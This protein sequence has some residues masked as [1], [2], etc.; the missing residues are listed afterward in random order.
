MTSPQ[1]WYDHLKPGTITSILVVSPQAWSYHLKLAKPG[2]IMG[3][4]L[5]RSSWPAPRKLKLPDFCCKPGLIQTATSLSMARHGA[6]SRSCHA[7]R[8]LLVSSSA[9]DPKKLEHGCRMISVGVPNFFGIWAWS[10]APEYHCNLPP[11][12]G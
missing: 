11:I 12:G 1:A 8:R 10:P 7:D 3:L 2:I 4:P 5:V 9:V 6:G